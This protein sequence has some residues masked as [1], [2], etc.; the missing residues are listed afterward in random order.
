MRPSSAEHIV[1]D[2]TA[3]DIDE[4]V[5]RRLKALAASDRLSEPAVLADTLR[6]LAKWRQ[7]RMDFAI[8]KGTGNTV[9]SGPFKGMKFVAHGTHGSLAPKLIGT[10]ESE[11]HGIVETIVTTAYDAVANIGAA[12][13]YYAVGL[14]RRMPKTR[15]LAYD[16]DA[17]A[18]QVCTAVAAANGVSDRMT[19]GG[20]F[21]HD[22]FAPLSKSRAVVLCDIEG[23]ER[24]LIDPERAPALE[25]LDLLVECHDCM[26]AGLSDLIAGRFSATHE[27]Q[28]INPAAVPPPLP[29]GVTFGDELDRLIA[30]WEWRVGPT[31]WLWMRSKRPA[32]A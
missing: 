5:G 31:P 7:T 25:K 22:D 23:A 6:Y 19:V 13:G 11:L 15:A 3:R 9:I 28:R 21:T 24:E 29:A 8:A 27:I 26:I 1:A 2:R 30:T 17:R 14:A 12:E 16:T 18:Q 32:N 4:L 10:Y 20:T